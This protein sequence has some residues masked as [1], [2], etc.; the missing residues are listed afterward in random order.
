[1][2]YT[3]ATLAKNFYTFIAYFRII[4]RKMRG[5]QNRKLKGSFYSEKQNYMLVFDKY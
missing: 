1:M 5:Y 3:K 2:S 4:K